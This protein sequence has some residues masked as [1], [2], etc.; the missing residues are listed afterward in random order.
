MDA[1]LFQGAQRD[2]PRSDDVEGVENLGVHL[3]VDLVGGE[4]NADGNGNPDLA[5]KRGGQRGSDCY[6]LDEGGVMGS[7]CNGAGVDAAGAVTV[8][9]GLHQH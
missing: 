2:V 7:Q 4:G 1:R 8:D 9:V 5:R 3:V 6:S